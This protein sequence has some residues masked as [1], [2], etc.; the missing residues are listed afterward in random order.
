LDNSSEA[1]P[2]LCPSSLPDLLRP[3]FCACS[4]PPVAA[5]LNNLAN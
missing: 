2:P 3:V 4:R 1:L 5:G